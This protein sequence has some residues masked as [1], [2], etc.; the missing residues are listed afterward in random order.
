VAPADR[1]EAELAFHRQR[2]DRL[3]GRLGQRRL[4][5]L[6]VLR[7]RGAR[8]LA[9]TTD[10]LPNLLL[11]RRL[12]VAPAGATRNPEPGKL[13]LAH[14]PATFAEAASLNMARSAGDR[15]VA[16]ATRKPLRDHR[17]IDRVRPSRAVTPNEHT[18]ALAIV[19]VR[20]LLRPDEQRIGQRPQKP[21]SVPP[22][23]RTLKISLKRGVQ[24]DARTPHTIYYHLIPL[25]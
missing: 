11:T 2:E 21:R 22:S 15:P 1:R 13:V 17:V 10:Q 9:R 23:M 7:Q 16:L 5:C 14:Q 18:G 4:P 19:D 8:R 6:A 12:H 25:R 24:T 20:G 3:T